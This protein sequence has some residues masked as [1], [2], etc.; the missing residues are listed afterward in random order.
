MRRSTVAI[1]FLIILAAIVW[2]AVI[3]QERQQSEIRNPKSAIRTVPTRLATA[4][5]ADSAE[6]GEFIITLIGRVMDADTRAEISVAAVRVRTPD[7]MLDFGGPSFQVRIPAN[8]VSTLTVLAPGYITLEQQMKPHYRRDATLTMDVPLQ[9]VDLAQYRPNLDNLFTT[10][11]GGTYGLY[12][13]LVANSTRIVVEQGMAVMRYPRLRGNVEEW[14]EWDGFEVACGVRAYLERQYSDQVT[15]VFLNTVQVPSSLVLS[16]VEGIGDE[17]HPTQHLVVPWVIFRDN[18]VVAL[19]L[20]PLG[21]DINPLHSPTSISG[22]QERQEVEQQ[23]EAHRQGIALDKGVPMKVVTHRGKTYYLLAAINVLADEYQFL[24]QGF[25]IQP[26]TPTTPL[27]FVRGA[28]R[29]LRIKAADFDQVKAMMQADPPLILQ[30]KPHLL[31]REGDD[32]PDLA[33][34]LYDNLDV[35]YYLVTKF[36]LSPGSQASSFRTPGL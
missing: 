22:R 5:L 4:P 31:N 32:D 16:E 1:L 28:L 6:A 23:F 14:S 11:S 17:F 21:A 24:L 18:G 19:D 29:G 2:G 27:V 26:A 9:P 30:R 34:V 15:E 12:S 25:E 36:E 3:R 7:Q 10:F 20:T 33:Q 35:L 13:R 8:R